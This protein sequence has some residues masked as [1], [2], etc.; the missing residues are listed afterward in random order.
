MRR[1]LCAF[2]F[3]L[4]A[5]YL[6]G[7]KK[8]GAATSAATTAGAKGGAKTYS[9]AN[10]ASIDGIFSVISCT[11]NKVLPASVKYPSIQIQFS[12][13][14]VALQELGEPSDKSDIVTIEP[15]LKGVFRWYGTSLLSFDAKEEVISQKV[16]TIK[17]NPEIQSVL[18]N[19][20]SGELSYSF[21]PE[22]LKMINIVPGYGE[23]KKGN[24]VDESSVP[25][26]VARDILVTFNFPVNAA[27]VSKGIRVEQESGTIAFTAVQENPNAVRL[28]LG[29][30][31]AEDTEI[32]VY[33]TAGAMADEGCVQTTEDVFRSFHTLIP[34]VIDRFDSEPYASESYSN[35]VAFTFSSMLKQGAE[36]ELAKYISS[37]LPGAITADNLEVNG[38]Q[39]LVYGLPVTFGSQYT[40]KIDGNFSDIYGRK[41]GGEPQQYYV[42]VPSARSYVRFQDYG[43]KMLEAQ[44][45]PRLAFVHQN[46]KEGSNYSVLQLT[47]GNGTPVHAEAVTTTLNPATIPQNT[48]IVQSVD[49][50]P[51]LEHTGDQYHG[52]VRFDGSMVYEYKYTDWSTDEKVTKRSTSDN[53]QVVQVTDLGMTVRYGYNKAVVLVT[54]LSTGEPAANVEVSAYNMNGAG[55]E[56]DHYRGQDVVLNKY[57]R[58]GKTAK[59]DADGFAVI[60]FGKGEIS[61]LQNSVDDIFFEAKTKDDRIIFNPS[62]HNLW[63]GGVYNTETPIRAEDV[64]GATFI[65]TDRGLYKPGETMTFRGIDRNLKT[66]EYTPYKGKYTIKLTD[67]SWRSNTFWSTEGKTSS[68][69]TFWGK[70]KLPETLEPGSYQIEYSRT[71]PNGDSY[72]SS[73]SIEIQFFERLRFEVKSSVPD[74]K[75]YS[76]DDI[77]VDVAANYLGGGS[78][79]GAMYESSWTREKSFISLKSKNLEDYSV[80]PVQGYDYGSSLGASSGALNDDGKASATQKSGGEKIIGAPYIYRVQT[81]VTDEGNQEIAATSEVLVHPARFYLALKRTGKAGFPKKG[82]TV[83]FD[84][85]PITPDEETPSAADLGSNSKLNVELLREEWKQVQQVAWNGQINTRYEREM[86]SESEQSLALSSSGTPVAISVKPEHG[87]EYLLRLSSKDSKGRDV[88][89][90]R[91]FYVTSSDWYWYN[92][93][94]DDEITMTPNKDIYE[95]GDTAQILMQSPVPKGRYL[96]TVEREGIVSQEIRVIDSPTSVIEIPITEQYV[97][98]MYVTMSSYTV[99]TGKLKENFDSPDLDKPKGLFGVAALSV[100]PTPKRFDVDITMDKGA[101]EP[102]QNATITLHATRNGA[103]VKNAE[104]TLMAVDRGVID[105][106]NYHVPDPVEYFYARSRFPD[107]VR[108]GDSR[109]FLIDPVT[110]EIKNL[111]GGDSDKMNERKNFDPT[112]LFEPSLVTDE[113]GNATCTFKLPDSL[114]AYRVTAVGVDENRFALAESEMNVANPISVRTALPRQLRL[115]DEGEVGVVISNLDNTAHDVSVS[116]ALYSGIEKTGVAQSE[117]D[118]QKLPGEA[119]LKGD[120]TKKIAAAGNKT[121]SLMFHLVANKPG[122]ITIEYTVKSDLVNEKI[123]LPLQIEKPYIYETVTTV[124]QVKGDDEEKDTAS[125][126]E[127]LI[128]PADAEDGLGELYV[129]LDPTRLGALTEAISYVFHYPYGCLEQRSAAIMPLVAFDKYIKMFGL[130]SEV[131]NPKSVAKK[132]IAKWARYQQPDGGFPYWPGGNQTNYYVTMRIAEILALAVKNGISTGGIDIGELTN[133][134][135]SYGNQCMPQD[136]D[137]SKWFDYSAAHAYYAASCLGAAIPLSN[138]AKILEKEGISPETVALCGLAYVNANKAGKAKEAVK[139]LRNYMAMTARGASFTQGYDSSWGYWSFFNDDTEKFALALQLFTSVEPDDQANQHLIYELL[140]ARKKT[141]GYWTSTAATARVLIAIREY[142]EAN[143]L[144]DLNFTA[145][146]LLNKSQLASGSFKGVTADA[147]DATLSFKEA[148]LDSMPRGKELPLVFTKS[149]RGDLYYTASMKY[150]IP[151]EK[152]TARDEGIC[153]FTQ[154]TDVK[155]GEMVTGNE[156]QSGHVYRETVYVSTTRNRSYMAVRAPVPAGCEIINAAFVTTGTYP[157]TQSEASEYEYDEYGE[158]YYD[159]YGDSYSDYNYGLSYE[160]IYDSEVQYFWDYFPIGFQK[161]EFL[162][163]T[164]RKGEYHTPCATAECMYEEEIF[165]RSDGK[166]WKIQ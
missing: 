156:L 77:S 105:L 27:V 14:V 48:R 135:I 43:F 66:G 19:K 51:S 137:S 158:D 150:A 98:V 59:T 96:L 114:T 160:G 101:Y 32:S 143:N 165:G 145:E 108:G 99:R 85:L 133:C 45:A 164:A 75:F 26:E 65:F 7:C 119:T 111:I 155:T 41:L 106:I 139:K 37:S 107:C 110:Y 53:T 23:I 120:T 69:G 154:I 148:P 22:L 8:T 72:S 24:Y 159:G 70:C 84:C 130:E 122:W 100:S 95:V 109:A 116:I 142:I 124:G 82:D 33:L 146:V 151:A 128:L 136:T 147:V 57:P 62:S 76:G 118:V 141:H 16:Y 11:P 61:G 78:L 2:F 113:N 71:L 138:V 28:T 29:K 54:K 5:V 94:N 162:F 115:N 30:A 93:N 149:G 79:A 104:I 73:C 129:Q 42:E 163:R 9:S 112:A 20:I 25:P 152:Q 97:P 161:V 46:I 4:S 102:G 140:D 21:R 12:E 55:S 3:I 91:Y 52:T 44:F 121:T 74:I 87:G 126:E 64:N 15:A 144:E 81:R 80:G 34:F 89:T 50:A 10:S 39:L 6:S 132:E 40:L 103:P 13:P 18:G 92:R 58:L 35:P 86:V 49:L 117:D 88:V 56:R 90:E 134:L 38:R 127:T 36:A 47:K 131:K 123:L 31:P 60:T 1:L 166:T 17:I 153:I 63:A 67:G 83:T 157:S 68:N 125:V